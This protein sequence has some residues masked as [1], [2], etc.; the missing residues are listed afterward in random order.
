[1]TVAKWLGRQ[2]YLDDLNSLD[3]DLYK[4]LISEC[5]PSEEQWELIVV[6]KNYPKPEELALN[7]TVTEEGELIKL[8]SDSKLQLLTM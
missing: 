4:G 8:I 3:K 2:S 1:M 6:L 7:F 5:D